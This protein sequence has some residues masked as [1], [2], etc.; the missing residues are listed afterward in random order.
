M[1]SNSSG[2]GSG[3]VLGSVAK[4]AQPFKH[5]IPCKIIKIQ[6]L[7]QGQRDG[8]ELRKRAEKGVTYTAGAM[9]PPRIIIRC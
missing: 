8:E 6:D 7:T 2:G 4:P 9:Y 3:S 5:D 1:L